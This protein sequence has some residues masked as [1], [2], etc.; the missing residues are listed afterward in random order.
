MLVKAA[1]LEVA[2]LSLGFRPI[3]IP[4]QQAK[5]MAEAP[6]IQ[7]PEVESEEDSR[8]NQPND[9][10][11]DAR[12]RYF[13]LMKYK[14]AKSVSYGPDGLINRFVNKHLFTL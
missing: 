10:Q 11:R 4:T 5:G 13:D 14:L 6:N 2:E 3:I 8:S 1:G 9:D 7:K 12:A